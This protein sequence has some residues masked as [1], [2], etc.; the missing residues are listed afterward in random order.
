MAGHHYYSQERCVAWICVVK[1]TYLIL[2][3]VMGSNYG[4]FQE[5]RT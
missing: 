5:N 4:Y 2:G 1:I 3:L